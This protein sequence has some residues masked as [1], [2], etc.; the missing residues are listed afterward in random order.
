MISLFKPKPLISV[1]LPSYNHE[2]YIKEAI[3]TVLN[4]T[5]TDFEL[6]IADDGSIDRTF[7]I[8]KSFK[9]KRISFYELKENRKF[10]PRNYSLKHAHGKYIAFQ[11]SD[12]VW[13]PTKLEKQFQL[14][15]KYAEI[16]VSFTGVEIIDENSK[17]LIG[18]WAD[19][20]FAI[21][22]KNRY[23]WLRFFFDVGNCLCISSAMVRTDLLKKVGGFSESL[24][25]LSDFDLWVKMAALGELE[26]ISEKLSKMRITGTSNYSAPSITSTNR[27]SIEF[28]EVLENYFHEPIS[29]DYK[30][31]FPDLLNNISDKTIQIATLLRYLWSKGNPTFTNF[32]VHFMTRLLKGK[33]IR[34]KLCNHFGTE[35]IKEYINYKGMLEVKLLKN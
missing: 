22:N 21:E 34:E 4:Q 20:L 9:D 13:E 8:A 30:R 3:S 5:F 7:E 26:I 24:F 17:G 15:E 11:N 23:E 25:N 19:G 10:N 1:I 27:T 14:M 32:A 35:I 6:I 28:L 18:S 29:N 31:I 12:D 33:D 2:K 16:A